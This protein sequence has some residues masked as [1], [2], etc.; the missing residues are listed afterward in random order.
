MDF[1]GRRAIRERWKSLRLRNKLLSFYTVMIVIMVIINGITSYNTYRYMRVFNQNLITYFDIHQLQLALETNRNS[2]EAYL[3]TKAASDLDT[4]YELVPRVW[5]IMGMVEREANSSIEAYFQIR[6]AQRGLDAYFTLAKLAIQKR[7]LGADDAY[8]TFVRAQRIDSY[9][10]SYVSLLLN[11]ELSEG[12]HAYQLLVRQANRVQLVSFIALLGLGVLSILFGIIFANSITRPIRRVADM[13]ARI[14]GG[15]LNVGEMEVESRDEVGILSASFNSMSRSIQQMVLDLREKADLEKRLHEEELTIVK[16][17]Q[18]LQEAQFLGLQSQ[19]NPHFLFNTLNAISRTALFEHA[20]ETA[21][22]IQ[23]LSRVF[24][25]NLRDPSKSVTLR[26]ELAILEEYLS[27]QKHRY[28]E[29]LRYEVRCD[30]AS[31]SVAIPCFTLQPLVENSVKYG[32]EPKEEG[33]SILVDVHKRNGAVRISV[34]DTGVGMSRP[35]VKRVLS[36]RNGQYSGQTSG[37]GISNVVER[38]HLAY[39]GEASFSMKSSP[40]EG[41]TITLTIPEHIA[42]VPDVPAVDSGR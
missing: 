40:G 5:Q 41:T 31:E 38:L 20:N 21:L 27:I 10:R 18:S 33:G 14:A 39:A 35:E 17:E 32:I 23:S 12:S 13:S 19:I 29:R 24:R 42:E 30:A 25:Y 2:L 22:L 7:E 16:M 1:P 4:Y 28:K 15:D 26:E 9:V 36:G 8:A 37:I 3:R 6:A 11:V 34:R